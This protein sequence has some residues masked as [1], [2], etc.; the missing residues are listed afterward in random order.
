M[1]PSQ[2]GHFTWLFDFWLKELLLDGTPSDTSDRVVFR[3]QGYR[4]HPLG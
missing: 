2:L 4:H 1:I 3:L